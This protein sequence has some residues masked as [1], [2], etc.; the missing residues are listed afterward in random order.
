[1]ALARHIGY[2]KGYSQDLNATRVTDSLVNLRTAQT[3][4]NGTDAKHLRA[5]ACA[6][7]AK[8]GDWY[9]TCMRVSHNTSYVSGRC[10]WHWVQVSGNLCMTQKLRHVIVEYHMPG[11]VSARK[12]RVDSMPRGARPFKCHRARQIGRTPARTMNCVGLYRF[13]GRWLCVWTHAL[14]TELNLVTCCITEVLQSLRARWSSNGPLMQALGRRS[15]VI[16]VPVDPQAT[17]QWPSHD[18]DHEPWWPKPRI[19]ITKIIGALVDVSFAPG[20]K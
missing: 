6:S 15:V 5:P 11:Y 9:G 10:N 20:R 13:A 14:L 4:S 16:R 18:S 1:M 2:S 19:V 8:K 17:G 12:T 7:L 3:R